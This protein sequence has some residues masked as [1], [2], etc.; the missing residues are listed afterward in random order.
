VVS[1]EGSEETGARG[2]VSGKQKIQNGL[3]REK[4]LDH[5]NLNVAYQQSNV[6]KELGKSMT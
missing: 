6:I 2:I 5:Y 4:I 3:L 1:L